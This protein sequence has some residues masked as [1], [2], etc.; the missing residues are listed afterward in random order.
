VAKDLRARHV[1]LCNRDEN[2]ALAILS[3]KQ[4][5]MFALM[6]PKYLS[7]SGLTRLSIDYWNKTMRK[8][9]SSGAE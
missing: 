6:R 3:F 5:K 9:D 1:G 2:N 7:I 4:A 8:R